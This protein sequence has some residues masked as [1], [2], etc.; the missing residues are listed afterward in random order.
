MTEIMFDTFSVP[1]LYISVSSVLSLY[2]SGR[3]TGLVIDSGAGLTASVPSFEGYVL[4][5]A[6][7]K[8]NIAGNNLT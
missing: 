5:Y 7:A 4:P 2:S 8:L 3:T 6:I 1:S